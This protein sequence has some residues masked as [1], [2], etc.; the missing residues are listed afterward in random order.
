LTYVLVVEA[1]PL[2]PPGGGGGGFFVAPALAVAIR[3]AVSTAA[4]RAGRLDNQLLG[5]IGPSPSV[6]FRTTFP[7][8]GA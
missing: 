7:A 6:E 4:T 5:F 3:A 8:P 2:P 1:P